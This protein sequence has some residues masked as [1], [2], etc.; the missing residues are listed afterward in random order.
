[1]E[2]AKRDGR[3]DRGTEIRNLLFSPFFWHVNMIAE[4]LFVILSL[5]DWEST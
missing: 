5:G 3:L 2:V 4:F 1:M